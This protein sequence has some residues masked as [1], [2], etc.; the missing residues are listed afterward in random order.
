MIAVCSRGESLQAEELANAAGPETFFF[1]TM[2]EW[3]LALLIL[4]VVGQEK[5]I[6][7]RQNTESIPEQP[8][9]YKAKAFSSLQHQPVLTAAV[10]SDRIQLIL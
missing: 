8:C 2:K 3:C 1:K 9:Q 6:R 10:N 5:Q 7:L 4:W